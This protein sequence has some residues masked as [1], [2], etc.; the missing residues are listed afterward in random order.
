[1]FVV[2]ASYL[3]L[4]QTVVARCGLPYA[5]V[6]S[7]VSGDEAPVYGIEI[8]VPCAEARLPCRSVLF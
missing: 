2:D 5:S 1:M 4:L 6:V 8:E 7:E 3:P